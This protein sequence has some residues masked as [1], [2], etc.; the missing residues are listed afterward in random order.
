MKEIYFNLKGNRKSV[1]LNT[2]KNNLQLTYKKNSQIFRLSQSVIYYI[3]NSYYYSYV[4]KTEDSKN[5][6]NKGVDNVFYDNYI[7]KNFDYQENS[8]IRV[9]D[10]AKRHLQRNI[11]K[12]LLNKINTNKERSIEICLFFLSFIVNNSKYEWTQLNAKKLA[13]YTKFGKDNTY[14][15]NHILDVLKY[16]KSTFPPLIEVLKNARGTDSY[17]AGKNSKKFKLSSHFASKK[18]KEIELIHKDILKPYYSIKRL[19]FNNLKDNPIVKNILK[20]YPRITYPTNKEII[21][22]AR[23][24]KKSN[25]SKKGKE[26]IFRNEINESTD[27][28][29]YRVV[30]DCVER[31][32]FY[33]NNE[34]LSI[35]TSFKAG[36]RITYNLN[37]IDSWIR[38]LIKIDGEEIVEVDFVALH[39]NLIIKLYDGSLKY[40]THKFISEKL[41]S[42]KDKVKKQHLSYFN[43]KI[44][45]LKNYKVHEFYNTEEQ[46]MIQNI[47]NDKEKFGHKITSQKLFELETKIMTKTI[48]ILNSKG[49][50]LV[51]V[52]DALGCKKSDLELVK[53]TMEEVVLKHGVYTTVS[54]NDKFGKMENEVNA[55]IIYKATNKLNGEVYIGS[56]TKTIE[57]RKCDHIQR[58]DK[59]YA[60]KFHKALLEYGKDN[61]EWEEIDTAKSINELAEKEVSY[62]S[63]YN[64]LQNGY[65]SDTG[66][67]FKKLVYQFKDDEVINIFQSLEEASNAVNKSPNSISNACLGGRLTCAGYNWANTDTFSKREDKRV[68]PIIQY[69]LE[70]ELLNEFKS[71]A[72]AEEETGINK[73]SIAK[74]CRGER[75]TAG[76]YIWKDL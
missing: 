33:K 13:E 73:S 40:I 12:S 76:G 56:T 18:T 68:K 21:T 7:A 31:F 51:Y 17:E 43:D 15:Y 23:R 49:V 64:S 57:E 55:G 60:T 47:I 27:L 71:I 75:N 16:Q 29:K 54:I 10:G 2:K 63:K 62:I 8:Q 34:I 19:E 70:G 25:Y 32:D 20:L 61:F 6:I 42:S 1:N 48:E 22:E 50:Y 28:S 4:T 9:P 11:P 67:G 53:T 44:S 3:N 24:L 65:N 66:G 35:S 38:K 26:L 52:Y 46:Q 72:I 74:C 41:N 39:P 5:I 36:G 14:V 30:E 69:S 59:D 37:L 58:L 45:V